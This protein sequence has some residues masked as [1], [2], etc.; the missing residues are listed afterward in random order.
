MKK[1]FLFLGL[2]IPVLCEAY[3]LPS[4]MTVQK[5]GD[6]PVERRIYLKTISEGLTPVTKNE[7]GKFLFCRI[8]KSNMYNSLLVTDQVLE[9]IGG[10]RSFYCQ[11]GEF[12]HLP[13]RRP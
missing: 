12:Y 10:S 4:I 8:G 5:Y 6:I 1:S 3:A 11:D 9:N 13:Y 7:K 2:S